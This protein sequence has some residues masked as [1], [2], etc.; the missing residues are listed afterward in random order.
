MINGNKGVFGDKIEKMTKSK[1]YSVCRRVFIE[2]T[3]TKCP[4]CG[5]ALTSV[6]MIKWN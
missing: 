2:S 6:K 1:K 3:G 4:F 5:S